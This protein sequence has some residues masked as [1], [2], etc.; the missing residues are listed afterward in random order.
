MK[1]NI[2][3][4]K[5]HS[6]NV[7][8]AAEVGINAAVIFYNICYWVEENWANRRNFV[9]GKYWTYNSVKAFETIFP[10]MTWNQIDYALNKLKKHGYIEYAFLSKDP[11]DRT[12]WYTVCDFDKW[13]AHSESNSEKYEMHPENTN[14]EISEN[15]LVFLECNSENSGM[16][17]ENSEMINIYNNIHNITN[18]KQTNNSH[19]TGY[20]TPS[21]E[22][23]GE[24]AHKSGEEKTKQEIFWDKKKKEMDM[25][26]RIWDICERNYDEDIAEEI[27]N[28]LEYF[29]QRFTKKTG[30][31]HPILTNKT[32]YDIID[33]MSIYC[34]IKYGHFGRVIGNGYQFTKLIDAYFDEEFKN[35]EVNWNLSHFMSDGVLDRL[36][37]RLWEKGEI[38]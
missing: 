22:D 36:A 13:I 17:Q 21:T 2:P 5:T 32:L 29:F 16:V 28:T 24:N 9:N 20:N 26:K 10:E 38:Y 4:T 23:E 7:S 6:Y 12:K 33:R 18:N 30:L 27:F 31:I 37:Q 25:L 1:N 11:M 34:D 3:V 15:G 8:V 19:N 14:S 35:G